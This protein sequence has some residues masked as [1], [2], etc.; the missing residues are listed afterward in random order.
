MK[1]LSQT[2]KYPR[3]ALTQPR[4]DKLRNQA[5]VREANKRQ[6]RQK[7]VTDGTLAGLAGRTSTEPGGRLCETIS[8]PGVLAAK[9]PRGLF[10][11]VVYHPDA[12]PEPTG[13]V[14]NPKFHIPPKEFGRDSDSST[15]NIRALVDSVR[16]IFSRS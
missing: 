7:A 16:G 2:R 1:K 14:A 11:P 3:R 4:R 9:A 8:Q 5:L 10:S 13:V 15:S 12:R 6:V